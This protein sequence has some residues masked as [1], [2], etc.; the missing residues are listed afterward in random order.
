MKK[1]T[2]ALIVIIILL[3]ILVF[4]WPFVM[5]VSVRS[6]VFEMSKPG[7]FNNPQQNLKV[8]NYHAGWLKSDMELQYTIPLL[9][10]LPGAPNTKS[11]VFDIK[12][13]VIN[14]PIS[15]LSNPLTD[16]SWG[17][18]RAAASGTITFVTPSPKQYPNFKILSR[19]IAFEAWVNWRGNI[20]MHSHW[21]AGVIYQ[22]KSGLVVTS[23]PITETGVI[24]KTLTTIAAHGTMPSIQIRHGDHE[25]NISSLNYALNGKKGLAD[26]WYG[27]EK[28][29]IPHV[30][31]VE[32]KRNLG[33]IQHITYTANSALDAN[34]KLGIKMNGDIGAIN[35]QGQKIGPVHFSMA[36]NKLQPQAAGKLQK[37]LINVMP[38]FARLT[39]EQA[40]P[41]WSETKKA[42]FNNQ[43]SQQL[44]ALF[45]KLQP[46]VIALI[47]GSALNANL[48][49]TVPQGKAQASAKITLPDQFAGAATDP[50]ALFNLFSA[51][52]AVAHVTAAKPLVMSAIDM[53]ALGSV[54]SKADDG[55]QA[56]SMETTLKKMRDTL[57]ALVS[58]DVIKE[59]QTDYLTTMTYGNHSVAINGHPLLNIIQRLELTGIIPPDKPQTKGHDQHQDKKGLKPAKTG[60]KHASQNNPAAA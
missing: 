17:W 2:Y 52:N 38:E 42:Q 47:T 11:F 58:N 46:N 14:G 53:A 35:A 28:I 19:P 43:Q 13:H 6:Q 22:D 25:A 60:S 44:R 3:I 18:G 57:Q 40:D 30:S 10:G 29:N 39:N 20:T 21:P 5:G 49:V 33:Q 32:G 1:V 31:V 15:K 23:G 45:L 56:Q 34:Q 59:N 41:A 50:N 51:S 26:I 4:I 16:K 55:K 12:L 48:A 27:A 54:S 7:F 36:A 37:Q 9:A 8:I 24:N